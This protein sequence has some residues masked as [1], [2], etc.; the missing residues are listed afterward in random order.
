V[1]LDGR[2]R[3]MANVDFR[4]MPRVGRYGVD[5]AVLD[6]A[7]GVLLGAGE[8]TRVYL[9]DEIGKMECLS[10]ALVDA[11]RRLFDLPAPVVA[12]IAQRGSGFIAQVKQREDALLWEVTRASRDLL[13]ERVAEWVR[14]RVPDAEES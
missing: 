5:V 3:V 6:E 11:M 1:T 8:R 7:A 10:A 12:T 2:Q 9:V 14:V 13:P 4:G